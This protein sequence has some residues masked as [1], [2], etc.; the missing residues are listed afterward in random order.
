MHTQNVEVSFRPDYE[1]QGT[2]SIYFATLQGYVVFEMELYM[3]LVV[4]QAY[5]CIFE[6]SGERLQDH[7]SSG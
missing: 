6:I 1:M 3:A 7:W 4:T 5:W 2:G